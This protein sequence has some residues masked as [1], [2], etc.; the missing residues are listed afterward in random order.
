MLIGGRFRVSTLFAAF[1]MP[2]NALHSVIEIDRQAIPPPSSRD[3]AIYSMAKTG[4]IQIEKGNGRGTSR[5]RTFPC[6]QVTDVR[7]DSKAVKK[8]I[9]GT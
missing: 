5:G 3:A 6:Y 9:G 4:T 2:V 1:V 7:I 8:Y